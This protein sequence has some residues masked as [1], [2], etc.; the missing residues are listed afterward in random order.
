MY[1]QIS[2]DLINTTVYQIINRFRLLIEQSDNLF[3][4]E[5]R[6]LINQL[7]QMKILIGH[8]SS[9]FAVLPVANL[10]VSSYLEYVQFFASFPYDQRV[11]SYSIEP[12]YTS[13]NHTLFLPYG[14]LYLTNHSIEYSLMKFL[15]KTLAQ[16]IQSNPFY[17]ECLIKSF[18]DSNTT[19]TTT[20]NYTDEHIVYLLFRS[21]FLS[22]KTIILDE[23]LWAFM[24]ANSLMKQFLINYTA[25]NYC[26]NAN[27]SQLFQENTFLIDDVHL[28]FYC[29][30]A[31]SIRQSKCTVN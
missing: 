28:V 13:S 22:E 15:L 7:D 6:L 3:S 29:Q 23:Y 21:K 5:K 4:T 2:I 20:M 9:P 19:S 8:F 10:Q 30:Q 14:F 12:I 31:S 11:K 24:S 17:I 25:E 27:A 18:D 16:T 1:I 26:P